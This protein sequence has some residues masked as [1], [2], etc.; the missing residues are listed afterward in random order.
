MKYFCDPATRLTEPERVRVVLNLVLR[1]T[2]KFPSTRQTLHNPF[3]QAFFPPQREQSVLSNPDDLDIRPESFPTAGPKSYSD[4]ITSRTTS[5]VR[6]TP[7][8]H[9]WLLPLESRN[10]AKATDLSY[11]SQGQWFPIETEV[12]PAHVPIPSFTTSSGTGFAARS[13]WYACIFASSSRLSSH[14]RYVHLSPPARLTSEDA[15]SVPPFR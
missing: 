11:A 10:I 8:I 12:H 4:S 2:N 6:S 15:S 9:T 5:S 3:T 13:R 7:Q 1:F 14:L